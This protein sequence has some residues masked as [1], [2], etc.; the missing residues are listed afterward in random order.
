MEWVNDKLN[1][2]P[3]PNKL[4]KNNPKPKKKKKTVNVDQR[5][6]EYTFKQDCSCHPAHA[7]I[8]NFHLCDVSQRNIQGILM[9]CSP[10]LEDIMIVFNQIQNK[11]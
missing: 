5:Q 10:E 2:H 9:L 8:N 7:Y 1:K 6:L 3:L 11:N 4:S